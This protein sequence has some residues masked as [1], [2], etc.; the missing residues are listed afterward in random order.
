VTTDFRDVYAAVLAGV[1]GAD[2]DAVLGAGRHP[3]PGLWR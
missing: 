3:V 2:P 1:L